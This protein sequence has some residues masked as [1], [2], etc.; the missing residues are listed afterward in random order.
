MVARHP[1][2]AS[3]DRVATLA[4]SPPLLDPRLAL[5]G[6][7]VR[8]IGDVTAPRAIDVLIWQGGGRPEASSWAALCHIARAAGRRL[9][10]PSE[11]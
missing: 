6:R 1:S 4:R 2:A 11:G 8:Q 3:A 5:D 7:R 10:A 9:H